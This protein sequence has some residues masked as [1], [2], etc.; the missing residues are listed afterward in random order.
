[1]SDSVTVRYI[2]RMYT[3]YSDRVEVTKVKTNKLMR[4]LNYVDIEDVSY[5]PKSPFL[6]IVAFNISHYGYFS[7]T[8][9]I[10]PKNCEG[11]S[12]ISVKMPEEEF[13]KVRKL[14]GDSTKILVPQGKKWVQLHKDSNF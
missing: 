10:R 14:I 5:C 8:F 3:F 7:N 2:G 4:T 9:V 13:E 12:Y 6:K 1:M 11:G